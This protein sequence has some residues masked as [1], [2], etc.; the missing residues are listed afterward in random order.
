[1]L[2]SFPFV[3]KIPSKPVPNTELSEIACRTIHHNSNRSIDVT[4]AST[5]GATRFSRPARSACSGGISSIVTSVQ[6]LLGASSSKLSGIAS[7]Q[8]LSFLQHFG[9]RSAYRTT[10]TFAET[11]ETKW[12]LSLSKLRIQ[13]ASGD[14]CTVPFQQ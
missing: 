4:A 3:Q 2:C 11:T 14:Q 5:S 13:L 9:N 7:Q 10:W 1:M 8:P 12:S 6:F